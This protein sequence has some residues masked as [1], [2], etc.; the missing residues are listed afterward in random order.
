MHLRIA[1]ATATF[2]CRWAMYRASTSNVAITAGNTTR[3]VS[4]GHIPSLEEGRDIPSTACVRKYPVEIKHSIVW[5]YVG[6][7]EKMERCFHPAF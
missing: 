2:T 6:E 5:I 7:P 1:V 4:A 3:K